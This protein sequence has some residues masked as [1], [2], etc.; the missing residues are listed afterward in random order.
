MGTVSQERQQEL[1]LW[2]CKSLLDCE[3][4]RISVK[5]LRKR[6]LKIEAEFPEYFTLA[7][8]F[9]VEARVEAA[10]RCRRSMYPIEPDDYERDEETNALIP[11]YRA[12]RVRPLE[13]RAPKPHVLAFH[14]I[15]RSARQGRRTVGRSLRRSCSSR[16]SGGGED[17]EPAGPA[18]IPPRSG[19]P[20]HG[21]SEGAGPLPAGGAL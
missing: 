10:E 7:P 16:S 14:R 18:K 6:L 19:R 15:H 1:H 21:A 12:K 3:H 11:V 17:G 13:R 8:S 9:A 4:G 20:F 2:A 5:T